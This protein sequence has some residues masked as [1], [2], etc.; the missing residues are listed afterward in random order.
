MRKPAARRAGLARRLGLDRNELRRASDLIE[1]WFVIVLVLAFVPLSV[2]AT[3]AVAHWVHDSGKRELHAE[4]SLRQ[5]TGV[6]LPGAPAVGPARP[7]SPWSWEPVRWTAAGVTRTGPAPVPSGTPAGARVPLWINDAGQ[8]QL[9]PVTATQVTARVVAVAVVTP[10]A[11]AFFLWL[12]WRGLRWRLDRHRLARWGR[13][14]SLVEPI[15]TRWP[16]SGGM[17]LW[18]VSSS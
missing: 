14:W 9:P 15:W 10:P 16:K 4:L 7:P 1:A 18:I 2:L 12:A 5:V 6:L 13:A 3:S 17:L 8:A 11:V